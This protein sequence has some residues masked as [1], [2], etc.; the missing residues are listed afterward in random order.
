MYRLLIGAVGLVA[1]AAVAVTAAIAGDAAHYQQTSRPC[2]L[3]SLG[4]TASD[5]PKETAT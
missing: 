1:I 2:E 5:R 4:I 3:P